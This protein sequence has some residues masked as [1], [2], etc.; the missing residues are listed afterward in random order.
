M[1]TYK[2]NFSSRDS[3]G[4]ASTDSLRA[5]SFSSMESQNLWVLPLYSALSKA[6]HGVRELEI[7]NIEM[8]NLRPMPI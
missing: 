6:Y 7:E 4:S 5:F 8:N 2:L 1:W 3:S